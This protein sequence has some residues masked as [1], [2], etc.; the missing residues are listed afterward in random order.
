MSGLKR[1]TDNPRGSVRF[2]S[3]I[4]LAPTSFGQ[5]HNLWSGVALV[6]CPY[7]PIKLLISQDTINSVRL[8][9]TDYLI[10][11]L[12]IIINFDR[13]NVNY[14]SKRCD[15]VVPHTSE[16]RFFNHLSYYEFYNRLVFLR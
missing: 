2:N 7:I 8:E 6:I 14:E 13:T 10:P 15:H 9:T 3:L 1:Y 5:S 12:S 11:T 4:R 16:Y